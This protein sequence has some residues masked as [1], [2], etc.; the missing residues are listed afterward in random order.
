MA[1]M[2]LSSEPI[3]STLA[4]DPDLDELVGMFVSEMPE[5]VAA[6][7]SLVA[8]GDWD[9]L[10]RAAHQLK[11]AAGSYGF[12]QISPSAARLEVAI[13]Q[14]CPE[15]KVRQAVEDLVNLCRRAQASQPG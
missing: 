4:G 8:A 7:E 1:E 12:G 11:G 3:Y 6:L 13:R 15:E 10:R 14:A 5:R 2:S 9:N